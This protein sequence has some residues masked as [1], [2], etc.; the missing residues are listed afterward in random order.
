MTD[1][2]NS[3]ESFCLT[4]YLD[5]RLRRGDLFGISSRIGGGALDRNLDLTVGRPLG[6]NPGLDGGEEEKS[7]SR[8]G[9]AQSEASASPSPMVRNSQVSSFGSLQAAAGSSWGL[10]TCRLPIR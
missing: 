3:T 5:L 9:V 6:A 2:N 8:S 4:E 1:A 7:G 10:V